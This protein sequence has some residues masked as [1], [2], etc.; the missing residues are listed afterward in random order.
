MLTVTKIYNPRHSCGADIHVGC[1]QCT[2]FGEV[3]AVNEKGVEFSAFYYDIPNVKVGQVIVDG[4]EDL[5]F[6]S[7]DVE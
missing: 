2:P 7:E 6:D 1:D 4:F 3:V 5:N